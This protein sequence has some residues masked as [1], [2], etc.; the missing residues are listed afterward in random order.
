[1]AS[2]YTKFTHGGFSDWKHA[3]CR[4]IDHKTSTAHFNAVIVLAHHVKRKGCIGTVLAHQAEQA[5]Q[6]AK[7]A[8]LSHQ[9]LHVSATECSVVRMRL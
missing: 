8:D 4:L 1:M 7:K 6:C 2:A 5:A 3:S 9:N